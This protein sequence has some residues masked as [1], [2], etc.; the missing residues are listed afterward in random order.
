MLNYN[1]KRKIQADAT[2]TQTIRSYLKRK[3]VEFLIKLKKRI[4]RI[5][6]IVKNKQATID[7]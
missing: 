4:V 7:E 5:N 1:W 2:K 3:N 6:W